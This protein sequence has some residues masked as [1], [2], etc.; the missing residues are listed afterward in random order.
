MHIYMH[1]CSCFLQSLKAQNELLLKEQR[2]ER[3]RNVEE[4]LQWHREKVA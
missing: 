2:A 3:K 4:A 1:S